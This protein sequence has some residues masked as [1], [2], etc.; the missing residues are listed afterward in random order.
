MTNRLALAIY[1]A[2][3]LAWLVPWYIRRYHRDA[4]N[5][6]PA[7]GAPPRSRTLLY[8]LIWAT[9]IIGAATAWRVLH[10]AAE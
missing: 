10:P 9:I 6:E 4:S 1:F 8:L 7:Q 2:L 5:G 3:W